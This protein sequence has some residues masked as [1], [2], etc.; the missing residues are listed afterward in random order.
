MKNIL[1]LTINPALDQST[2][3]EQVSPEKKLRC[4]E[5]RYEP[6]G[7][8]VNVSRAIQRLGGSSLA[9]YAIGGPIGEAMYARL[10]AEGLHHR[11]VRIEG[12]TRISFTAMERSSNQQYR[13]VMPGPSMENDW[14]KLLDVLTAEAPQP[15]WIVAS[16]S[17]PPGVPVDFYRRL[18]RLCHAAGH[19][20]ILDT[21]G[22][23]LKAAVEEGV[24]LL[25]PNRRELQSLADSKLENEAQQ[26]D[27]VAQLMAKGQAE[28]VVVSLGAAGALA[29]WHAGIEHI[30]APIVPIQSKIGA[31]DSM[32]AGITLSLARQKSLGEAIR[33]GI[34]AGTSAVS[35]PGTELCR[36]DQTEQLYREMLAKQ[37]HESTATPAK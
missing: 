18:A 12:N 14:Q 25:K 16:G 22:D 1:T 15:S 31:G 23:G 29:G 9:V 10:D 36:K 37:K 35:T 33:F 2:E 27:V 4:K 21:S 8:G 17:L 32:V 20:L 13:F 19:K 24:Y 26:R 7:G 3:V 11:P 28:V 6:G 5:T 30:P 34:A